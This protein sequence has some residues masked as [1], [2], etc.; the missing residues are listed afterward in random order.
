MD[1]VKFTGRNK[2]DSMKKAI[3]FFYDNFNNMAFEDFLARC[4]YDIESKTVYFYPNKTKLGI[5]KK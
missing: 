3:I 5:K 1:L 4:R 2:K